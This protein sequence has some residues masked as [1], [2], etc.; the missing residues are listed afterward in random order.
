M[1]FV[2][3]AAVLVAGVMA[4][5]AASAVTIVQYRQTDGGPSLRLTN[6]AAGAYTLTTIPRAGR[7][8]LVT[9]FDPNDAG[10]SQTVDAI[11]Q[12]A[13]TG[14]QAAT[15]INN[16]AFQ[17]F[18]GG[19]FSLTALS[20]VTFLGA[21]G[22][23]ILS[24]AFTTATLSGELRGAAPTFSVSIPQS[25]IA[26][27]SDFYPS[28]QFTL[29]NFSLGMSDANRGLRLAANG[30]IA[31][32]TASSVGTFGA[33]SAIPEPATWALMIIGFGMVGASVRR[34]RGVARVAN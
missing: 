18:D 7:N 9:L 16:F 26:S 27:A 20:P 30:R 19:T 2:P 22:V 11:F 15:V 8:V 21:T 3:M 10:N 5:S 28:N 13:A 25:A 31:N 12:F 4:A 24:G 6:G 1:R 32:F 23:N 29:T 33:T 34:G 17:E 14:T